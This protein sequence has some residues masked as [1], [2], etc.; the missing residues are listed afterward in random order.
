[1]V[2]KLKMPSAS[3]GGMI[4]MVVHIEQKQEQLGVD[5]TLD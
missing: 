5:S 2:K 1:M 3:G 4:Y